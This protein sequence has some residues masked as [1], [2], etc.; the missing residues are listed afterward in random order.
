MC[1]IITNINNIN[2]CV[3]CVMK[4]LLI[5]TEVLLYWNVSMCVCMYVLLMVANNENRNGNKILLNV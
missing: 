2:V 1:V 5:L 3:I 4:P